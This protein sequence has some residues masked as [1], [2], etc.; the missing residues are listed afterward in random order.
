MKETD[1]QTDRQTGHIYNED[2]LTGRPFDKNRPADK[3]EK[4][5]TTNKQTTTT[6]KETE[7]KWK[8]TKRPTHGSTEA[9]KT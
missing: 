2:K 4:T 3:E 9:Q 7:K 5:T 8:Q 1:R 6:A